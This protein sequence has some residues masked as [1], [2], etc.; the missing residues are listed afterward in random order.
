MPLNA[1]KLRQRITFQSRGSSVDAVGQTVETWSDVATV[2]AAVEPIRGRE[3]IEGL[4]TTG[5]VSH[6]FTIRKLASVN[7][8]LRISYD[9]RIF[10]IESVIEDRNEVGEYMEVMALEAV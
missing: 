2:W 3:F 7:S 9:S 1:G 8:K 4:Q 10:G 6:K 5:R